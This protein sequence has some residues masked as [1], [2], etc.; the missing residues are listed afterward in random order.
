MGDGKEN[1]RQPLLQNDNNTTYVA[2]QA[3]DF[4]PGNYAII[5]F[6]YLP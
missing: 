4:Q 1:E 5:D 6:S 2:T 3:G